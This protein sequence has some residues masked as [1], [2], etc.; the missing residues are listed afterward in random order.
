[1]TR[2]EFFTTLREGLHKLPPEEIE[3][4][5][6]YYT[7]YLDEAGEENEQ[8]ALEELG[9][10]V[11][12]AQQIN[13]EYMVRDI[14]A[15]RPTQQSGEGKEEPK[16]KTGFSAVWVAILALF[17]SPIALPI[18][19]AIAAVGIALI[20]VVMSVFASLMIAVM[21]VFVAGVACIASGIGVL[22]VDPWTGLFVFGGGLIALGIS[23]LMFVPSLWLIRITFSAIARQIS[24]SVVRRPVK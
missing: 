20:I 11:K 7:E 15:Y 13:A 4:A 23:V 12:I 16:G 21:A 8:K 22:F 10:P 24:R 18:A 9:S 5:V 17:A 19:F 3:N 14:V 1:M 2:L 6:R